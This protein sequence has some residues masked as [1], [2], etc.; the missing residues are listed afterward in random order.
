MNRLPNSERL[1]NLFHRINNDAI[2]VKFEQVKIRSTTGNVLWLVLMLFSTAGQ[3]QSEQ[4]RFDVSHHNFSDG[5]V[6]LSGLG[7]FT[8]TNY[9]R[10]RISTAINNRNGFMYRARGIDRAIILR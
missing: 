3:A 5:A 7:N 2:V 8:G 10:Q 4:G 6:A 9:S 1:R